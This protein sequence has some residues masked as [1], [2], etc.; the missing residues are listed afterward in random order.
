AIFLATGAHLTRP[1]NIEGVDLDGVFQG[2]YLLHDRAMGKIPDNLF[3]GKSVIVIGGGNVAIDAARTALRLGAKGVELA[4]LE[5]REEMP[6]H[7]WE[8]QYAM[9]EGTALNCSWGPK[10]ILGEGKRI[11]GVEFIRCT[12]VFDKER[13]FNPSYDET[14][15]MSLEGDVVIIAIGQAPDTS[16]LKGESK[17]ELTRGRTIKVDGTTLR[18]AEDGVFAGGDVVSGAA[19]VIEAIATGRKAAI[20]IDKYLGGEG[21]IDETLIETEKPSPWLGR[22]EGFAQKNRTTMPCLGVE[23]R[24]KGFIDV[25][26]GFNKEMAIE[27]AKRCL[28]CDLRL[29]ISSPIFPPEKRT[30]LEFSSENIS[31]IPETEGVVQLLD[32]ERNIIYI[33]GTMNLRH[34]LEELVSSAEAGMSKVRY[35]RY[36]ENDMYSTRESELIQQFMQEHGGLP[37]LNEEMLF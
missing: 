32:A 3:K 2:V 25:E 18:T 15:K 37:E 33:A 36:E 4:C 20:S 10:R 26:L 23:E 19:S 13:R 16:F 35:F 8:I 34:A 17:I 21:K 29:Q 11:R 12:S 9:E 6:A 5:S 31:N 1:L 22:E 24:V 27:E 30:V 7:P 14:V 28:Q